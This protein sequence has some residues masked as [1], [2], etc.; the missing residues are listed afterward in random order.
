M[1]RVIIRAGF[2]C[3]FA[4]T[5][6]MGAC[7]RVTEPQ[8]ARHLSPGSAFRDITDTTCRSGYIPPSGRS[9]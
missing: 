1:R 3:L 8:P 9:C 4:V 5:A 2:A 7:T 6:G